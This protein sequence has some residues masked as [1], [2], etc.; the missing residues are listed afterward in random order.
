MINTTYFAFGL[1]WLGLAY[2]D[3]KYTKR[4]EWTKEDEKKSR[5]AGDSDELISG[6]K[7]SY[8]VFYL[9]SW[10]GSI[11]SIVL[12]LI[13]LRLSFKDDTSRDIIWEYLIRL[14]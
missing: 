3:I 13:F 10:L 11:F 14:F 12:G 9:R 6:L 5:K 4:K 1:F 2:W 8:K 7:F